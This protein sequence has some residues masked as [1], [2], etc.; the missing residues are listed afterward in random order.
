MGQTDGQIAVSLNAHLYIITPPHE[1]RVYN[2]RPEGVY[3]CMTTVR[4]AENISE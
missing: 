1:C 3:A 4:R 2:E